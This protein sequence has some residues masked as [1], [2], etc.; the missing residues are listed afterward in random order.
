MRASI[1]DIIALGDTVFQGAKTAIKFGQD[2]APNLLL[3][4]DL[5]GGGA[6]TVEQ[7]AA[8]RARNDALNAEIESQTEEGQ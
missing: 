1:H 5:F 2:A 3:L 6:V 4:K 7:L 8:I